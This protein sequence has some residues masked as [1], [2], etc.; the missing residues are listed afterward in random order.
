MEQLGAHWTDGCEILYLRT[1]INSMEKIHINLKA[2]R[3]SGYVTRGP[4]YICGNVCR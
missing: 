1:S 2:D 3:N 4:M